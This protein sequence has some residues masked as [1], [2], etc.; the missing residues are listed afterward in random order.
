MIVM[1]I[2]G[3]G[4]LH[5]DHLVLD[6]NG[7]LALDGNLLDGVQDVLTALSQHVEVH[8]LTANTHGQQEA[9]DR[10]LGMRASI[11]PPGEEA[12]AK[13]A[14][15]RDLDPQHVVAIGQGANDAGMLAEAAIGIC[16]LSGEGIA[17][18]ALQAADLLM[19]DIHSALHALQN[20]RRLVATLRA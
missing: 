9:I 16:V 5:I 1:E 8:M 13:A 4:T 7:T 18:A 3:R 20:P 6:V 11:I 17:L 19:P 2:P 14:Y 12:E 10:Q 15:V